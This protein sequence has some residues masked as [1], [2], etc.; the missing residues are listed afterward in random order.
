MSPE[1]MLEGLVLSWKSAIQMFG[2]DSPEAKEARRDVIA[3]GE[4]HGMAIE[5]ILRGE[6]NGSVPNVRRE[7]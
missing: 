2:K 6:I 4:K 3:F 5:G 1:E 7:S